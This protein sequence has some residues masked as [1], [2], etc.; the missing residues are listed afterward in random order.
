MNDTTDTVI[1]KE[2]EET[3]TEGE[4]TIFWDQH[5]VTLRQNNNNLTF[6]PQG[7]TLLPRKSHLKRFISQP[8]IYNNTHNYNKKEHDEEIPGQQS[9]LDVGRLRKITETNDKSPR[10]QRKMTEFHEKS[11]RPSRKLGEVVEKSP[12]LSRKKSDK[13]GDKEQTDSNSKS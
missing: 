4:T 10:A 2:L 12:K 9:Y 8:A 3:M 1:D 6:I 13:G 5:D 11:P 7:S